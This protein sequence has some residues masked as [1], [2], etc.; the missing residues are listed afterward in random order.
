MSTL[1]MLVVEG[2]GAETALP[3]KGMLVL[4]SSSE[5]ADFLVAG[6]GVDAAHCAIGRAKDGSWAVKDLGSEFGTFLNGEKVAAKRLQPGDVIVIGSQSLRVVDPA[7]EPP[8]APKPAAP[9]TA[10]RDCARDGASYRS[11]TRT[12]VA[13]RRSPAPS[14]IAASPPAARACVRSRS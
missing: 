6:Q 8:P 13:A 10:R 12:S 4:G 11:R 2:E 1:W 7:A 5:R 14:S 3:E 9:S